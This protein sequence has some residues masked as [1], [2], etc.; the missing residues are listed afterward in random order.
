MKKLLQL[1]FL[2]VSVLTIFSGCLKDTTYRTYTY[3]I[4]RPVFQTKA[5]VVAQIGN[6]APETI[7]AAGK[8]Y[9]LGHYIFLNELGK[10]IHVINNLNPAA[11]I[12]ESFIHIPGCGD[13]AAYGNTL[14]ADC[15][16]DLIVLN[17]A[18]PNDVKYV[19]TI[20][21]LFPERVY[22]LGYYQDSGKVITEWITKDT[23]VTEKIENGTRRNDVVFFDA[24]FNFSAASGMAANS[25][26]V[27]TAPQ[28]GVGGSMARFAIQR[29][30]LYT[31]SNS[32]LEVLNISQPMNPVWKTKTSLGWGIETIYP[33]KDK[34]FIG[35][36]SG[37]HIYSVEDPANPVKASTFDHARVCDPVIADDTYAYVTLR[38]GT[39]CMGYVNQL[40]VVNVENIFSPKLVK[41]YPLTNPH[42][43]SKA[44][45]HLFVCD[46]RD[47]LRILDASNPSNVTIKS[48]IPMPRTFD[49]I[50]FNNVAIVSAEDGLYQ[51][52]Y[53]DINN[54]KLLSRIGIKF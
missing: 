11:P 13:M 1:L 53:S 26:G 9:L 10:G 21:N 33:F 48:T 6:T 22:V 44:G 16:T 31:V 14:Y 19:K 50:C 12:V 41:S 40:D 24:A 51:Y 54:I 46:G 2:S 35:A 25:A 42:G 17:I 38:N 36:Q 47:G 30:H 39:Q 28:Q 18:Q 27:K 5:E 49:V 45:N 7:S 20:P 32:T 15:Y 3:Q 43:L 52:D 8:M 34:L 29:E 23:I 37:M 4:T